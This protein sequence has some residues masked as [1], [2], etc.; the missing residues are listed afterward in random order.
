MN[1]V[2]KNLIQSWV[3][4]KR[5][6]KNSY[7]YKQLSAVIDFLEDIEIDNYKGLSLVEIEQSLRKTYKGYVHIFLNI[8]ASKLN[9]SYNFM[10]EDFMMVGVLACYGYVATPY[11]NGLN[12]WI[13]FPRPTK[14]RTVK[15][16]SKDT[17]N[18]YYVSLSPTMLGA[19][20][21]THFTVQPVTID[22]LYVKFY[23]SYTG[24][25]LVESDQPYSC[26]SEIPDADLLDYCINLADSYNNP[27]D[28]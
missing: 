1:A 17:N 3:E 13:S 11:N 22:G 19:Y 6:Y 21:A 8:I 10:T 28:Y 27:S 18:K 23:V 4:S 5:L 25:V 2:A 12:Y 9:H 20:R 26:A 15:Y 7:L 16:K 24:C 14:V